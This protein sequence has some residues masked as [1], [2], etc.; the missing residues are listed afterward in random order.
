M[1]RLKSSSESSGMPYHRNKYVFLSY[2]NID[3]ILGYDPLSHVPNYEN[4]WGSTRLPAH[5]SAADSLQVELNLQRVIT[6]STPF[7]L[8]SV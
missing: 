6:G 5:S 4:T 1:K 2:R 3:M 7:L 8:L